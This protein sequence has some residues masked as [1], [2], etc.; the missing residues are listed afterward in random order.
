[1]S[2]SISLEEK[3]EALM[4]SYQT[5]ATSNQELKQRLDESEG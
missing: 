3:F 4:R 2:G 5:I 1:M